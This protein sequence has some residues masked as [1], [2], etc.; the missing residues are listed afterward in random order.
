M[1]SHVYEIAAAAAAAGSVT[2]TRAYCC[3][4]DASRAWKGAGVPRKVEMVINIRCAAKI[5]GRRGCGGCEAEKRL[6]IRHETVT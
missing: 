3:R 5:R 1:A 6:K 4:L 2:D